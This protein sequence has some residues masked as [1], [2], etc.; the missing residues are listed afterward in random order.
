MGGTFKLL[1]AAAV[2]VA[3]QAATANAADTKTGMTNGFA[4]VAQSGKL[5]R[6]QNVT[7]V[8]HVKTGVYR[9]DFTDNTGSC[10]YN[11]T[12][13]GTKKRLIPGYVVVSHEKDAPNSVF[14]STFDTVTLL[15]GDYRFHLQVAC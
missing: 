4:V 9:V 1:S 14:V 5:G 11:A 8:T 15:P 13:A 3:F 10:A 2:A 12:I 6:N 7:N